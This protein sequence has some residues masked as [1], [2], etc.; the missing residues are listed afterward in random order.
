ML[1]GLRPCPSSRGPRCCLIGREAT[2]KRLHLLARR[3]F[4]GDSGPLT[5]VNF[6]HPSPE[7]RGAQL[8]WHPIDPSRRGIPPWT[9]ALSFETTSANAVAWRLRPK[10]RE[11]KR[12]GR[13]WRND[14]LWPQRT[15]P[16][17]R[18]QPG[19]CGTGARNTNPG[20]TGGWTRLSHHSGRAV[21]HKQRGTGTWACRSGLFG[22]AGFPPFSSS[23]FV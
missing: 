20:A 21:K 6:S 9:S 15:K 10:T 16:A 23:E 13:K 11:R 8:D 4:Q 1:H 5:C 19:R 3:R 22:R 14:G 17:P 12:Y 7:L 18:R 2:L